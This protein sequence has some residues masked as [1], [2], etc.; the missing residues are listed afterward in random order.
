MERELSRISQNNKKLTGE[1]RG[2]KEDQQFIL[3]RL[4]NISIVDVIV[5]DE[6]NH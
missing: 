2:L 6:I 5:E 4:Q 3:A 1:V